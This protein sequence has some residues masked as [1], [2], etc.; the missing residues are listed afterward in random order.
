GEID[1]DSKEYNIDG[2]IIGLLGD[3]IENYSMHSL[4]SAKGCEF[5]NSKQVYEALKNLFELVLVP[6][7]QTGI[8]ITV[9][10]VTGN[11]DR[12]GQNRT[13]N[14]PGEE[15]FTYIIYNT[16]K[17]FCEYA[18]MENIVFHIPKDPW[19]IIEVYGNKVLYEHYDNARNPDRKG[20]ENLMVTRSNQ[21]GINID[22]MRGG[23]YHEP[24][25]FK[26]GR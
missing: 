5:G 12:D 11:H 18:G 16:L 22:Y 13:Y 4:E 19:C 24:T 15:N 20:L 14:S 26:N 8:P 6:L 21:L 25:S 2:I 17:D 3:I 23:H 1:R 10:G 9:V 7:Y